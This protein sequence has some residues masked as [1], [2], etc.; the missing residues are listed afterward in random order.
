MTTMSAGAADG[1]WKSPFDD[2][3]QGGGAMDS[4]SAG[5]GD[6]IGTP[7]VDAQVWDGKQGLQDDCAIKAQEF[8]LEQFTQQE[9]NEYALVQ[10]SFE[11][12]WYTPGHGTNPSDVGNLLEAHGVPV[13]RYEN[14]SVYDLADELAQGHK[15]VISVDS[16]E[17]WQPFYD[18]AAEA[19]G[20]DQPGADHAVVVSGIDTTD[21]GNI[22][23]IISDPGT[24][25]A[26]SSYPLEQFVGAWRDSNC[27]MVAT[28]EP[29][30]SYMPEMANFDY[31][32]GHIDE[33]AGMSYGEFTQSY[34]DPEA[35]GTMF[36]E[37]QMVDADGDGQPDTWAW[38]MDGDGIVETYDFGGDGVVDAA[39]VDSNLDDVP[40]TVAYDID[41]DGYADAHAYDTNQDGLL[42]GIDANNDGYVETWDSDGDGM[43]DA[44][45]LDGDG[46]ADVDLGEVF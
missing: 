32:T 3:L 28:A 43:M 44:Q 10:E 40:D 23:V 33:V 12:G 15:V 13:N 16:G 5:L 7:G 8:I 41:A 25:E 26:L 4:P 38:D 30:P 18:A 21:P 37:P 46:I 42:D 2:L 29:A 1:N 36:P 35:W 45:D 34:D 17:L 22:R 39:V 14:A 20:L 6:I 31:A 27:T 9:Y 24:G 19:Y 11:N